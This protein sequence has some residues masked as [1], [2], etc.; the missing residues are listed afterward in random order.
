MDHK[1]MQSPPPATFNVQQDL[2]QKKKDLEQAFKDF[3]ELISNKVLDIN[4]SP[5]IKKTEMYTLNVLVKAAEALDNI[6]MGEGILALASIAIREQL[7]VRDRVNELE[8]EI[9]LARRDIQELQ[10]KLGIDNGKKTK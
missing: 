7:I 8:Y 1:S 9:C 10:K 3:H 2:I 4:K 5:A 6:N